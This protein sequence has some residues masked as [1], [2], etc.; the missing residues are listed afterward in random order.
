[1]NEV[2]VVPISSLVLDPAN[3]RKHDEKNL[4]AIKGSLAR[5]GQQKPVVVDQKGVV[6]GKGEFQKSIWQVDREPNKLHPTM[7]PIRLMENAILNSTDKGMAVADLFSG[8]G[9]TLIA[10]EKTGRLCFGME[11]DEHY[12]DVIIARWEKYAGGKAVKS[13]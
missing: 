7:K 5:F 4:A 10:C 13:A 2:K 1:M 12:C 11:I 6:I 8:S 9:S 3:A